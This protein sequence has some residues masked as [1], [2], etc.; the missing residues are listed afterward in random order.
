MYVISLAAH[1]RASGA[2]QARKGQQFLLERTHALRQWTCVLTSRIASEIEATIGS[3]T[4]TMAYL[5]NVR[6]AHPLA[7][8]HME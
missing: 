8:K 2:G 1:A 5:G 6:S 4:T 3:V 7:S